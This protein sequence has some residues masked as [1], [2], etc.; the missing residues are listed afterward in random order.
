MKFPEAT[1]NVLWT[2]DQHMA[3][4]N[5][6]PFMVQHMTQ[7]QEL[8]G[9]LIELI[10]FL[11]ARYIE[12]Q[13]PLVVKQSSLNPLADLFVQNNAA[14][15]KEQTKTIETTVPVEECADEWKKVVYRSKR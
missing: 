1:Q 7:V 3:Y 6:P 4:F 10:K 14:A 5:L 12:E 8:N 2:V 11:T 9:S 15:V 13:K